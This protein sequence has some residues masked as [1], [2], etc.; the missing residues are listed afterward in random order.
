M[1]AL[2]RTALVDRCSSL[3]GMDERGLELQLNRCDGEPTYEEYEDFYGGFRN[4]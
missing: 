1:E 2:T 3:K 4:I